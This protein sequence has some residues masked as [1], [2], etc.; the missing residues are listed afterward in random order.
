MKRK[1][2]IIKLL[3]KITDQLDDLKAFDI[4]VIDI[5]N[6]SALADYLI[7]ATGNSSRHLNSITS[8]LI[9]SNKKQ[10]ISSEGLKSTDWSILDFGDIILNIFKPEAREHYSLEK[11]WQVSNHGEQKFG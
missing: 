5:K 6:R 3:K 4:V 7:I 9:K 10:I 2:N 11:I 1:T 8:N